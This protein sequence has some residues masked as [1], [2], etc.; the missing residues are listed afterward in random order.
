MTVVLFGH[1]WVSLSI[2]PKNNVLLSPVVNNL[3]HMVC[4]QVSS[5]VSGL[6][7][8]RA[9]RWVTSHVL[10]M[11]SSVR[12]PSCLPKW[13]HSQHLQQKLLMA[14]VWVLLPITINVDKVHTMILMWNFLMASEKST[15]CHLQSI[16]VGLSALIL[17]CILDHH[18]YFAL[19]WA[20]NLVEIICFFLC[21]TVM[22]ISFHLRTLNS[23]GPLTFSL[24]FCVAVFS[25]APQS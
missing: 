24:Q 16:L 6:K 11:I 23:F 19:F 2:H 20:F 1:T 4:L 5:Q 7:S 10:N 17:P 25:L 15:F 18:L 9:Q 14:E 21:N 22:A 8:L 13:L 3:M 12:L